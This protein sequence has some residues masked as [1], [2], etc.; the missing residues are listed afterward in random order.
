[1]AGEILFFK[2]QEMID[3]NFLSWHQLLNNPELPDLGVLSGF[4][5]KDF[6]LENSFES[7]A[8]STRTIVRDIARTQRCVRR[9]YETAARAPP[10]P[11]RNDGTLPPSSPAQISSEL[12][13]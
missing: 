2:V 12:F 4:R 11:N 10:P 8:M 7:M 9:T 13:C 1:M 3:A 5:E 6:V